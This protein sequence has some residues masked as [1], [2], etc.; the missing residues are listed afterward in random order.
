MPP[1]DI[2][3][4][5]RIIDSDG[6]VK[7]NCNYTFHALG[8]DVMPEEKAANSR[9]RATSHGEGEDRGCLPHSALPGEEARDMEGG[10]AG[11]MV[12]V[13]RVTQTDVL[14]G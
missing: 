9:V 13:R 11:H 6:E 10:R 4:P 2:F 3:S 8:A 5:C 7:G 14:E 1:G 12:L